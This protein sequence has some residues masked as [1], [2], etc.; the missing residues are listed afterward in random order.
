MNER[1]QPDLVLVMT[2]QQRFD[3]VGWL[4][5]SPVH[6]PN[7]DALADRGVVFDHSYSASTTCV[8]AR[9][10]LMTGV[11][12][13]RIP[14]TTLHAIEPG[15]F[16]IA[17][18][19]RDVGYQTAVVGKMHFTP[20]RADH[21]FDHL[22]VAEHFSAYPGNP[23][24]WDEYDHYHDFL[25]ARGLKDWRF[26]VPGGTAAPYPF[27]IETHPT[28]WVRDRTLQV[29]ADRDPDRP[30]L[31]IVSFPHP[32][33]SI[34][35]PEPYASRYDPSTIDVDPDGHQRNARLPN[36]FRLAL[37]QEDHP[38]RRVDPGALDRHRQVLAHTYGLITQIDDAVGDVVAAL[39]LDRTVLWF[40]SDHGDYATNRGLVRKIP[41][42]PFDDLARVPSFATGGPVSGGRRFDEPTQS[43]DLAPTFLELGGWWDAHPDLHDRFDGVSQASVLL[44]A[45]ARP[46]PDRTVFSALTSGWPM[47]RRG[48]HKYIRSDGWEGEVTFDVVTDPTESLDLSK[49]IYGIDLTRELETLVDAARARP[50]AGLPTTD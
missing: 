28:S 22:E 3:Q 47:V 34:N 25:A 15:E 46:D 13:H 49:N 14:T 31:L 24:D 7:L 8:P 40:T 50:A 6:T 26:E 38:E 19:L 29:L 11:F 18:A 27:P 45:T 43:F 30:L 33:P 4:P 44:D 32:H 37:A 48:P 21:G 16:T 17:R 20:M 39:D 10:S 41:W 1:N 2:D 42:I 35:P 5:G 12:D 36:T 23:R 9:T